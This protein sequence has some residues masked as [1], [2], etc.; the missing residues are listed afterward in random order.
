MELKNTTTVEINRRFDKLEKDVTTINVE[1]VC[2]YRE[3]RLMVEALATAMHGEVVKR[4]PDTRN[5]YVFRPYL[6]EAKPKP[7]EPSGIELRK[8]IS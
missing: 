4:E 8:D 6:S 3:L 5:P 7:P 2:A 1:G